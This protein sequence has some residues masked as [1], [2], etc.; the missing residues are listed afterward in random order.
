MKKGDKIIC[1]KESLDFKYNQTYTIINVFK[2]LH[3]DNLY[4]DRY[5]VSDGKC[6][7]NITPMIFYEKFSTLKNIRKEKLKKISEK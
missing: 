5:E 7:F 2:R 3:H 1:I 6:T 4:I